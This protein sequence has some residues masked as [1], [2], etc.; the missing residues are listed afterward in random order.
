[1]LQEPNSDRCAH[2]RKVEAGV[3]SHNYFAQDRP[4]GKKVFTDVPCDTIRDAF[5]SENVNG[6]SQITD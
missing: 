4:T 5:G 1:M 2:P 6:T 3:A